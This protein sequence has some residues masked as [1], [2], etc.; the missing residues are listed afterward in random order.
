MSN[1]SRNDSMRAA[2]RRLGSCPTEMI[3]GDYLELSGGRYAYLTGGHHS[4]L[5]GGIFSEM[6]GGVGSRLTG[7]SNS[8]LT[9]DFRSTLTGGTGSELRIRYWDSVAGH[10]RTAIAR[11][12]EDGI[13][14]DVAYR[15]GDDNNFVEAQS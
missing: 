3:G 14:P 9:G 5:S 12:G 11:V 15:I 6:T 2:A 13:K 1:V 7:G 4:T 8:K 10:P